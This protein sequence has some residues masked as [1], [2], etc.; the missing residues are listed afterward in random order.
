MKIPKSIK[1]LRH[2][3]RKSMKDVR[4]EDWRKLSKTDESSLK[5]DLVSSKTKRENM[6]VEKILLKWRMEYHYSG[7]GIRLGFSY[8]TAFKAEVFRWLVVSLT[9]NESFINCNRRKY[10]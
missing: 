7:I 1:T 6:A 10:R 4:V 9:N 8:N 2:D 3:E 5:K